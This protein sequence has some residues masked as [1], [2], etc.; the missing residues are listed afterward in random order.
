MS[1]SATRAE[2]VAVV[3]LVGAHRHR[4]LEVAR[5]PTRS[6]AEQAEAEAEVGVVVDRV[7]LDRRANSSSAAENRPL[8][9]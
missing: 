5:A 6:P 9:K 7:D 3:G 2:R 4:E 1:A 8:R